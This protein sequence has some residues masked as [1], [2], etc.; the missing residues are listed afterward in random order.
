[1][2]PGRAFRLPAASGWL[3]DARGMENP[4]NLSDNVTA[5]LPEASEAE[6]EEL[7]AELKTFAVGLIEAFRAGQRFDESP[8]GMV[9][10]D[11]PPFGL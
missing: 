10:S 9:D 2:S 3:W 6:R 8:G 7:A 11:S 4:R 5:Y 1:V